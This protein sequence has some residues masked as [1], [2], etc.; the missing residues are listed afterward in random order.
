MADRVELKQ[1]M[2]AGANCSQ[3]VLGA[4][5]DR[6]DY[7]EEELH[8]ISAAFGGGMQRGDT[9][10]A[11]SGALMALSLEYGDDMELLRQKVAELQQAFSERF[12]STICRELLGY[13]FSVPGERE[14]CAASGI[15][16]E[17]CPEY[18]CAAVELLEE[19]FKA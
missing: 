3:S 9:C 17:R 12:G 8:R 1:K 2:L 16:Q 6:F 18:V 4:F 7:S 15:K 19:I 14:R 11:V 13:D 5:A 10:G